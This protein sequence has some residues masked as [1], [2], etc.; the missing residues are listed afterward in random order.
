MCVLERFALAYR[1]TAVSFAGIKGSRL[2][3]HVPHCFVRLEPTQI[4]NLTSLRLLGPRGLEDVF[5]NAHGAFKNLLMPSRRSILLQQNVYH[6]LLDSG[7][8]LGL[9]PF[10]SPAGPLESSPRPPSRLP[11]PLA[12]VTMRRSSR[13][14]AFPVC[15]A[16]FSRSHVRASAGRSQ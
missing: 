10:P 12:P 8:T 1:R 16:G 5:S 11:R 14:M 7:P 3:K 4:S 9:C 13:S 15:V 6:A 2:D